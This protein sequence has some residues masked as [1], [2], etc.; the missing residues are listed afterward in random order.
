MTLFCLIVFIVKNW[1]NL[2]HHTTIF[3]L[4]I[5]TKICL[6]SILHTFYHLNAGMTVAYLAKLYL[7]VSYTLV[8]STIPTSSSSAFI[9]ICF[10][11]RNWLSPLSMRVRSP[12]QEVWASGPYWSSCRQL[13]IVYKY[14]YTQRKGQPPE[15]KARTTLFLSTHLPANSN[16]F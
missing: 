5:W 15:T 12:G 1:L 4:M 14:T 10:H 9:C 13:Y 16:S 6:S 3:R 8:Y 11:C 2:A 7:I